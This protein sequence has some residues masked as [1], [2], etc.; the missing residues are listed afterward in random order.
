MTSDQYGDIKKL[1]SNP[2]TAQKHTPLKMDDWTYTQ[3]TQRAI[4]RWTQWEQEQFQIP[5]EEATLE[6]IHIAEQEWGPIEKETR[7]NLHT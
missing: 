3:N 6:I 7:Q 2:R 5:Q 4:Q 1:R